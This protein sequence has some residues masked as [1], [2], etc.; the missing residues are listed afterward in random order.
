MAGWKDE[1]HLAAIAWNVAAIMR[2]EKYP[3]YRQFLDIPRYQ[4]EEIKNGD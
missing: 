2:M 4:K 1:D 3:C